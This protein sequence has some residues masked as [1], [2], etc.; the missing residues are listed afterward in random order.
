MRR[1]LLKSR[2]GMTILEMSV[3]IVV[4]L[5][6]S[7]IVYESLSSSIEFNNLLG[8]RDATTRAAR[9]T[10]SKLRREIQLAYLTPS[11]EA[12][13]T[14][15]TVFVGMDEEPDKLYFASLA[16]QRLYVD[17]RESDQ[18]EITV[19]AE[20][21]PRDVGDGY[22]LY[23]REAPRVDHEPGLGG[24]VYPLAYNVRSFNVRYLD[25]QTNE[26][27]DEWDTRNSDTLYRLPRAVEIGLVLIA[28]DPDDPDRT[29]DVPFLSRFTLTYAQNLAK[30]FV[31]LD[32]I[33]AGTSGV[34][35]NT[36]GAGNALPANNSPIPPLG[37]GRMPGGSSFQSGTSSS[38]TRTRPT[39]STPVRTPNGGNPTR[40]GAG[41]P[42]LPPGVNFN[43]G[44]G[45]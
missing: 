6:M 40:V 16:H 30:E 28:E 17:S 42:A 18:T 15:Q 44:G 36:D 4:L 35:A 33:A 23:H 5:V 27:R 2:K 38:G 29:I 12:V 45:K 7:L 9:T 43:R 8:K 13:E 20:S 26:W 37:G 3:A 31:G 25:P 21:S 10:L 32:Q 41:N 39:T 22:I 1:D 11:R 14:V 19:W 34:Q 24:R